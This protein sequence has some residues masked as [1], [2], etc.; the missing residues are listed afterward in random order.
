MR[1]DSNT[2]GIASDS[3]ARSMR[4]LAGIGALACGVAVG[5]GAYAMHATLTPQNHE[6]LAIAALF[7]F[8]HGLALATLAPGTTSRTRQVGLYVLLVGTI[9]FSGSLMLVALLGIAPAL[10]PFG[11]GLL[12]LGW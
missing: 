5:A 10:A 12:M 6:R 2:P 9:L 3:T 11:G 1:S 8:A 7:L 4:A